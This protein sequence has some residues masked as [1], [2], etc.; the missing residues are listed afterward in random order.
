MIDS[1][2]I[3]VHR[4]GANGPEKGGDPSSGKMIPPDHFVRHRTMG[5]LRGGL[6]TK[7]H[8]LVD[9]AG[10][11]ILLK[12]TP[13]QAHDGRTAIDMLDSPG[14]GQ[15][16]LADRGYDADCLR[17]AVTARGAVASI[18]PMPHRK[19]IP[20]FDR[21]LCS[22]R[23]RVEQF[24]SKIR[25]FRAVATRYGKTDANVLATIQRAEIRICLRS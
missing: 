22:Q 16:L 12:L 4:H 14:P 7:I 25:Q 3:R 15:T 13:W 2:L 5:R 20:A 24:C 1:S 9:A 18:K 19:R 21:T 17:A 23:N 10:R 11:P 6:T 8:A